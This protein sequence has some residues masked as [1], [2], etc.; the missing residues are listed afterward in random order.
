MR[1][2][3]VRAEHTNATQR[4]RADVDGCEVWIE[5]DDIDLRPVPEGFASALLIPALFRGATLELDQP[6]DARWAAGLP[7][8]LELLSLWWKVPRLTPAFPGVHGDPGGCPASGES[9]LFFSG[10]TDSFYSLL[11]GRERID[12]LLLIRGFDYDVDDWTRHAAVEST[13][14]DVADASGVSA[15][16]VRTNLREHPYFH[17]VPW[18]QTHGGVLAA[19]GHSLGDGVEQVLISA[20]ISYAYG[21]PW[22]SHWELDPLWSSTSRT[23]VSVGQE[24]R[25]VQKL[26]SIAAEPLVHRHL[27]VCWENRAPEG[28]CSR[29]YKCIFARLVLSE[30]GQLEHVKTLEGVSGL[31]RAIDELPRG[32]QRMRSYDDLLRRGRLRPDV[33]R[34]VRDLMTRTRRLDRFDVRWRR[35]VLKKVLGWTRAKPM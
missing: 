19:I 25:K 1:I 23:L 10:G 32:K 34:A 31:A 35:A 22:G 27:R 29:C 11:R 17:D 15:S 6:V 3:G 20:S 14:R 28:N 33:A 24:L 30:S 26:R 7:R 13:T 9:V 18:E 4:V 5:S 12:R 2:T 8:V 16:V 21:R